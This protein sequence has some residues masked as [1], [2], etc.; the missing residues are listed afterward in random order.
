MPRLILGV[1]D[2]AYSGKGKTTGE[3]AQILE[4]K[5][6]LMEHFFEL[7][8]QEIADAATESLKD[9]FEDQLAGS[10]RNYV[11]FK[12]AESTIETMFRKMIDSRELDS[13]GYPGIPTKA[14]QRGVSHRRAHPYAKRGPR[15]SFFD[16]GLYE[17]SF[18]AH[19]EE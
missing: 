2:V 6:H 14:A 12:D 19:I 9:F 5:Y 17:Q 10:R 3:V 18:K 15:P 4:D 7:H 16:T 1:V 8:G 11:S 13:L